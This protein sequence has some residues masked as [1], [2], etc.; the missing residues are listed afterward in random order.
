MLGNDLEGLFERFTRRH[1]LS[2]VQ[3]RVLELVARAAPDPMEPWEI[4][5]V[6]G[7]GS[8]HVTMVLDRLVAAGRLERV[9]HPHD[10]RRR[11]IYV[12]ES[13]A[14]LATRIAAGLKE[15]EERLFD[16]ALD[17]EERDRLRLLAGR[18]RHAYRELVIPAG[19]IRPGP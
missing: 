19:R 1:E 18:V 6:L 5:Q 10:G 8:N 2:L 16:A 15:I 14:A 7:L 11:R 4:A 13:G 9:P 12:T 17:A 3:A